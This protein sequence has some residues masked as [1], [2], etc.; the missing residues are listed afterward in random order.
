[1]EFLNAIIGTSFMVLTASFFASLFGIIIGIF[2]AEIE[3]KNLSTCK[4][5][6]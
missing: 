4:I 6:Y 3:E 5:I 1:M 2:L